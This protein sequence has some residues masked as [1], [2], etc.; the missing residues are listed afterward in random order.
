MSRLTMGALAKSLGVS[1]ATL[2]RQGV[3]GVGRASDETIF[4]SVRSVM[5][6]RGLRGTTLEAVAEVASTTAAP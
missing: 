4:A 1:R 3:K 5:G 6:K 2:Y